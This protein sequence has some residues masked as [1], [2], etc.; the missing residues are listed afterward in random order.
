M[1]DLFPSSFFKGQP[2]RFAA[3]LMACGLSVASA[4]GLRPAAPGSAWGLPA[5]APAA[6]RTAD[7]I[8]A[9]VNGEPITNHDVRQRLLR[10]EQQLARQGANVP[11]RSQ[12]LP[13]VVDMLINERA[14][15]QS[16]TEAGIR[17]DDA[18]L[19]QAEL[20][21]AAQNQ[22]TIEGLRQR[23]TAEGLDAGQFR[24]EL[25]DQILLQR[26]RE[27]EVEQRVKI[28]DADID[29]FLREQRTQSGAVA[30]GLDLSH[31]LV[32]VPENASEALVRERQARAQQVADRARAPGAN[33]AALAREFS[34]A[35]EGASGGGFGM[36]PA[37]R[38]P[39]L[40]VQAVRDLPVG[41]VA[42]PIR[43]PAGFHVLRLNER[44]QAGAPALSE[45]QTHARHILLRTGPQM[46]QAQA[47]AQLARWREE[48]S[49][50]QANF[51]TLAREHSQDG[52]A[53]NGGDLGWV[54][55]GQ[56]VPEFESV[57]D[58]LQP[59]QLSQ[60]V[61]SRFGVHLIRVDE[62]RERTLSDREQREL[63][64]DVL[65]DRRA[66]EALRVWMQDV[67]QRAFVEQRDDPRP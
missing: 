21:V 67:R 44:Q 1:T 61:V 37:D 59:G 60:P 48:I 8:V 25:R 5:A 15:V 50:G 3:V 54:G 46:S 32:L 40:F 43:S 14:L 28:T 31:V 18:S 16:A 6:S 34:D 10:V 4:Q 30:A 23:L 66:E 51:E 38:L 52:S 13:E 7:Y 27:R 17:V 55:P 64:R 41:G 53:S 19:N 33:F 24:R 62:R 26:A 47:V 35:P 58:A 12:L 22:L 57:M 49:A 20:S 9:L 56:F 2:L 11:N 65:R 63:A 39:E 29:A 36:R 42:G 45:V